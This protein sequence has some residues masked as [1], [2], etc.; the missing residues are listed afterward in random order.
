MELHKVHGKRHDRIYGIWKNMNAR[1]RDMGNENYGGRGI[2]VCK[3][4]QD[5]F[6]KFYSWAIQNGYSNELTIDRIDVNGNY[7]PDNCRW[8]RPLQQARNT[9]YNRLYEYNGEIKC[10]S[11]WCE[12]FGII[13]NT[14]WS[15]I[16]RGATTIEEICRPVRR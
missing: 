7:E 13:Y 1:C 5:D 8:V 14:A 11:E 2:T 4:W 12:Y 16:A 15:R 10:L 9:R 6:M 3:E